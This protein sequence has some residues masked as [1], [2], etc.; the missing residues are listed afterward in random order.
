MIAPRSQDI[1]Y[2]ADH[3][4]NDFYIRTND[5]GRTFRLVSAPVANPEKKN[6]KEIVPVRPDVMISD[7]EPF[8]DFYVLVERE[9]GLPPAY[10]G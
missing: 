2:Y 10:R 7:F 5:K 8:Q 3:I 9:N 1:E 4:G 6:W